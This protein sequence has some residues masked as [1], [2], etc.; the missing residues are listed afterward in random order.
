MTTTIKTTVQ[1][2][3]MY[4]NSI[5]PGLVGNSLEELQHRIATKFTYSPTMLPENVIYWEDYRKS[6]TISKVTTTYE[7]I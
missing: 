6:L 5:E 2:V 1:F 7:S 3:A 4:N